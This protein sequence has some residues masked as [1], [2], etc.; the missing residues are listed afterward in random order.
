MKSYYF[1]LLAVVFFISCIDKKQES[2]DFVKA[3]IRKNLDSDY[4]NALIDFTKA[5]EFD[6]T[7]S[8]AYFCRGNAKF[9]LGDLKGAKVDYDK[10]IELNPSYADAYCNRANIKFYEGDKDGACEDYKKAEKLGKANI[11]DNTRWCN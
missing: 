3:G 10:A 8:E 11:K 7:N 4:K 2:K 6:N 9:N 1:L 5:L